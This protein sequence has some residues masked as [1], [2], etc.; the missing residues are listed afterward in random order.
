MPSSTGRRLND[1]L[2][3]AANALFNSST[4][5]LFNSDSFCFSVDRSE[6]SLLL[7]PKWVDRHRDLV[8]RYGQHYYE[9]TWAPIIQPLERVLNEVSGRGMLA[10]LHIML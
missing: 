8:E 6:Q 10:C 4:T 9:L 2:A 1:E 5:Q 7:G 3:A